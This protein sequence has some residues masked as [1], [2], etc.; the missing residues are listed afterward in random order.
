MSN[1]CMHCGRQPLANTDT[2]IS[3]LDGGGAR[4]L[5]KKCAAYL[6]T[7]FMC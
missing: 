4:I 1:I 3:P 2:V 5:C 7:C 6:G